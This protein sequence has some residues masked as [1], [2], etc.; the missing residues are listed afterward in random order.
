MVLPAVD[1]WMSKLLGPTEHPLPSTSMNSC[2]VPDGSL[3][4]TLIMDASPWKQSGR[5][6]VFQR[7]ARGEV[8]GGNGPT[9]R[10]AR[11]QT[12]RAF[13]TRRVTTQFLVLEIGRDSAISTVSPILYSPFSSCAW[14]LRDLPTIF[15]Y[16]SCVTRRSTSTVT[17]LERLSETTRPTSLRWF[18][19]GASIVMAPAVEVISRPL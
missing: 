10:W 15:P 12:M 9:L 13:C 17:V 14:Y 2:S 5:A 1:F 3:S 7:S 4:P 19:P 16:R 18:L 8:H 11:V 6:P